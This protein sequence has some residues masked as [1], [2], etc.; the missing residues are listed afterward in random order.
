MWGVEEVQ[1]AIIKARSDALY[2]AREREVGVQA[3]HPPLPE[4]LAKRHRPGLA[5]DLYAMLVECKGPQIL[6]LDFPGAM[7]T[8]TQAVMELPED[9]N[10]FGT[11]KVLHLRNGNEMLFPPRLRLFVA[12]SRLKAL[13]EVHVR[14]NCERRHELF[15]KRKRRGV[16]SEGGKGIWERGILPRLWGGNVNN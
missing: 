14:T 11:T 1:W 10:V 16:Y 15:S 6:K 12:I 8:L 9:A 13:Q 4:P 5:Q 7:D 2:G 3:T